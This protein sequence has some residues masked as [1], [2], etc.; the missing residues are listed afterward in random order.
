MKFSQVAFP[1][2]GVFASCVGALS[3][4]S[5]VSGAYIV[6]LNGEDDASS[7]YDELRA[8]AIEVQHRKNLNYKLF[9]GASF[10]VSNV[11]ESEAEAIKNQIFGK[12]QVK[13]IWPVRKIQFP[14]PTPIS[15]G[16]NSTSAAAA[17][18]AFLKRQTNENDTFTPHVMTQVNKL[19]AE[20]ITGKGIKIGVVDTGVDY[21][22]PA[23]GGCFG[24]GC[25]ISY[26]Y[27]LTGDDYV[28]DTDE[29][30]PDPDPLDTCQ[31]HGTHVTG[32]IMANSKELDF[33]GAAPDVTLGM[34][35]VSSCAGYTTNDIL[36]QA[37]NQAFEEGSDVISCSVGD[38]SGWATD[39]WAEAASRIADAGVA[40]VV[41]L[42]NSGSLGMWAA[43]SPASGSSV[44]AVGS[45][46]NTVLPRIL[47]GASYSV[48][49][50]DPAAFGWYNG[51]PSLID[52]EVTFSLWLMPNGTASAGACEPLSDDT[53]DLS[54]SLVLLKLSLACPADQQAANI[55]AKGGQ[56][57]MFYPEL[58][59]DFS[60]IY[61]YTDG[62]KGAGILSPAQGLAFVDLL[63]TGENITVTLKPP[64]ESDPFVENLSNG[65]NAGYTAASSSWGPTWEVEI[66]PQFTAPGGMILS[67]YPMNMGGYAV[68]PGTS[69]A[70]PLVAAVFALVGQARGTLDAKAIREVISATAK[71]LAWND[72]TAAFDLP[73]PVAQQG[74]GMVQAY[75]AAHVVGI[76]SVSSFS[77]N[78]SDHFIASRSFSIK[79]T[80]T[81]EI[82]Y[83]LGHTK[84]TTVYTFVPD[85]APLTQA[86][87]PSPVA[88]DWAELTF[89]ADTV[90]IPAG[91][92][93][94]ISFTV[95]PPSGLNSTLLPVYSGY[96]TLNGTN[97]ET[98]SLPYLGVLGSL[99]DTP[100][101]QGGDNSGVYLSS[102][103]THFN[104]PVAANITFSIP[105]LG[106]NSTAT[107]TV[108]PKLLII[109]TVG[110]KFLRVDVVPLSKT[111]LPTTKWLGYETV[112]QLPGSPRTYV[113]RTGGTY[114]W[115]GWLAD[116]TVVDEGGYVLVTSALKILG[117]EEK[118]TDWDV[119][120]TV[121][122]FLKYV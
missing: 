65:Q 11:T 77:F 22:H 105:R 116:G 56:Y 106:S 70:T 48:D 21:T 63:S 79:N 36:I 14:Q 67:T 34:Y 100:V 64:N 10:R 62:I 12:S 46:D 121:P 108:W 51:Y 117:D 71:P 23:L 75:D 41:A 13:N 7:L 115:G 54:D 58:Q 26:G 76:P 94:E 114:T 112:G 49:G 16:G 19:R 89:A 44:V 5:I 87:F 85:V 80:G 107:D 4:A 82:S 45:V 60:N 113:A 30:I 29:P 90:T 31:G 61:I 69:M 55:V 20:G 84:S 98:L 97:G 39:V 53:P 104:I 52:A 28:S 93:A 33:T 66:K 101:L 91:S 111:S 37:F 2:L 3:D 120:E 42:G 17:A 88:D 6:E 40:V 57:L 32:I 109:P 8:N 99:H 73:A 72:G 96:L 110:T 95:A 47:A 83:E 18:N 78:D 50:N 74:A 35:K 1:L 118:E 24:P 81:E 68:L 38:D 15:T 59:H 122:F 86:R 103:V 27:D 92:T 102:T 43:A 9:K 119:V 25:A